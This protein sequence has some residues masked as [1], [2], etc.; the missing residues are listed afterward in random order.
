[1]NKLMLAALSF[2]SFA[3]NASSHSG[4]INWWHLGAEYKDAP[5]LGWLTITFIIFV[6][7]LARVLRQP[8]SLYLETRSKDIKKQIEEAR[9]AKEASVAKLKLY[10]EKL[11]TLDQEIDKMKK[12]FIDQ[13]E[14][15]KRERVRIAKETE[16]RILREA[17]DTI[18]ANFEKSKLKL[19]DEVVAEALVRAKETILNQKRE[20]VD[21]FLQ[22]SFVSDLKASAKEVQ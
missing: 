21:A 20:E 22:A 3:A 7:M 5:A 17:D 19:A 16:E 2:V 10:E 18:K 12:A 4:E 11:R 15:E 13:A 1:M 9:I 6:Y 8:L 14:S